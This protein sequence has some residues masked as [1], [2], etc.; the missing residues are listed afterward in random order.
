MTIVA[1]NTGEA[2]QPNGTYN[3]AVGCG[4]LVFLSGQT[5]RD[6]E[7]NRLSQL[8][9]AAQARQ[10]LDN[11]Q[12]VARA[13]GLSLRHCAKVTVYLRDP[14]N[15]REFDLIYRGYVSEPWPARTLVQSSFIDFEI[16]VDAILVR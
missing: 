9:F 1:V 16:E 12:A 8:S 5:P 10:A 11:L 13:S 2:P 3:Q 4:N 14:A 15:A 7:G 6:L